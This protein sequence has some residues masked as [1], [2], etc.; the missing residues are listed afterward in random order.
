MGVEKNV[1]YAALLAQFKIAAA[2]R[3]TG[4]YFVKES[5]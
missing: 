2:S 5:Q 4:S 3:F 1:D